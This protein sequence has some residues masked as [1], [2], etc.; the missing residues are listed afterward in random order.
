MVKFN[1]CKM[2]K[3]INRIN[4]TSFSARAIVRPMA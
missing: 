4:G 2:G 1:C 3:L